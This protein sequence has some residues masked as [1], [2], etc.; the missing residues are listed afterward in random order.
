MD[1][2]DGPMAGNTDESVE[3]PVPIPALPSSR[4][5]QQL[6]SRN[7]RRGNE[8]T[9]FKHKISIG[10]LLDNTEVKCGASGVISSSFTSFSSSKGHLEAKMSRRAVKQLMQRV[11][12]NVTSQD[13]L[14]D[15]KEQETRGNKKI[16][17]TNPAILHED[18]GTKGH[19]VAYVGKTGRVI[20]NGREFLQC[21]RYGTGDVVGCGVLLD[22]NTFFFTLNGELMGLLAARDVK[23][24]DNFGEV[25]DEEEEESEEDDSKSSEEDEKD[26]VG[27]E[28]RKRTQLDRTDDDMEDVNG[29]DED[30]KVLFPSVSLHGVGECVR[31]VFEPDEFQFDLSSFEQQIQKERQRALLAE[32]EKRNENDSPSDVEQSLC[33]DEA[34]MNELVQNF[35]LHNGYESAYKAFESALVFPKRQRLTSDGME[36]DCSGEIEASAEIYDVSSGDDTENKD[37]TEDMD[38]GDA[39][40]SLGATLKKQMLGSLRLRHEV[41]E[42]IRCFRAAQALALL[43]QHVP[44]LMTIGTGHRSRHIKKLILNCRILCVVD[45]LT[46]DEEAKAPILSPSLANGVPHSR[47]SSNVEKVGCNGWN[48]ESAIEFAQQIF[49]SCVEITTY[50]KRKRQGLTNSTTQK[51]RS[52]RNEIALAMSLLLYD[53]RDS[54]PKASQARKF[55]TTEFRESVADQLNSLLLMGDKYAKT[56]PRVSALETFMIDLEHLQKECLYHGCRAYPESIEA[57]GKF[58][59]TSHRWRASV[60][61]SSDDSSSSQS[62]QDDH[63]EDE[64]NDDE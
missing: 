41:R 23:D 28:N 47:R 64:D 27:A 8:K 60:S 18:L 31:A 36:M 59:T 2:E 11:L 40:P 29:H 61:S 43:E 57:T 51:K 4:T 14:E 62:E 32:C 26:S 63:F 17:T 3:I 35:F 1:T 52:D 24:L 55:L 58:N 7:A 38:I 50:G 49:G 22:T 39:Q 16:E 48:P 54:I 37:K 19:S 21:E 42:H 25:D 12:P 45:V 10:F 34:V 30:E 20:F 56:K 53:Q 13:E 33:K 5:M 15:E 46:H 9:K 6:G 44:A